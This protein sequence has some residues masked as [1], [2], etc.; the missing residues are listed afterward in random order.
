MVSRGFGYHSLGFFLNYA[1]DTGDRETLVLSCESYSNQRRAG[2]SNVLGE[3]PMA[4]G[5]PLSEVQRAEDLQIHHAG[6]KAIQKVRFETHQRS[7][8]LEDSRTNAVRVPGF[9]VPLPVHSQDRY[10]L[11]RFASSASKM[12][13]GGRATDQRR[14][15]HFR[16]AAQAG[17]G[18]RLSDR[19]VSVPSHPRSAGAELNPRSLLKERLGQRP[20]ARFRL[21]LADDLGLGCGRRCKQLSQDG[22]ELLAIHRQIRPPFMASRHAVIPPLAGGGSDG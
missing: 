2:L 15:R 9:H 21:D 18:G 5:R 16:D 14:K 7:K 4:P 12:V 6:V 8:G 22:V 13:P 10:C 19:V 3:N 11:Q 1:L 20:E 17:V